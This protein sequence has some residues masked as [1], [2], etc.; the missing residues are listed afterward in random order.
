MKQG[1]ATQ[2]AFRKPPSQKLSE[3]VLAGNDECWR[4]KG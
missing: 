2:A 3:N 4:Q 1:A